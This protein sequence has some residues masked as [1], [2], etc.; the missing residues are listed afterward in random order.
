MPFLFVDYDQGAGGERFCAGLSQSRKCDTLSYVRYPNGRTKVQDVFEQ[1]FL[2]P[3]PN[4]NVNVKSGV[5]YTIVPCHAHTA[6][7]HQQLGAIRSIRIR[8]PVQVD[9]LQHVR[10]QQVDKVLLTSEPTPEYFLGLV[11]ILKETCQDPDFVRHV[12]YHMTTVELVLLSQGVEPTQV[13]IDSYVNQVR[14]RPVTEPDFT[15]D[16]A[17]AYE[18]LAYRPDLVREQLADTFGIVTVGNWL[19]SYAPIYS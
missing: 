19:E 11:K 16:L 14:S 12:R 6:L 2:K 13:N 1:E 3:S 10:D 4:I 17:I 15:Y 9:L 18:D 7:A 8:M 5:N